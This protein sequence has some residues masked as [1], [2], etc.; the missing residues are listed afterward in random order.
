MK[1]PLSQ[2]TIASAFTLIALLMSGSI[3]A[4]DEDFEGDE[5]FSEQKMQPG[6]FQRTSNPED[7]GFESEDGPGGDEEEPTEDDENEDDEYENL[8]P[9][10][11]G[12]LEE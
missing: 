11:D 7:E 12:Y 1:Y 5:P 6:D 9:E 2:I 10:E 3:T 8:A 4:N